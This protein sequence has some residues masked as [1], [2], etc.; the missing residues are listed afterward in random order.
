M[1][2]PILWKSATQIEVPSNDHAA[3]LQLA[4]RLWKQITKKR[5][6]KVNY[7]S[8]GNLSIKTLNV[9]QAGNRVITMKNTPP[10]CMCLN[11][12]T[13]HTHKPQSWMQTHKHMHN[14][15]RA[16]SVGPFYASCVFMRWDC[17]EGKE[18]QYLYTQRPTQQWLSNFECLKIHK[19][20]LISFIWLVLCWRLFKSLAR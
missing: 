13:K 19:E 5:S 14:V 12:Y 18:L 3:E 7:F 10:T 9:W 8:R 4:A 20:H 1:G 17:R 6:V 15:W 16:L 11:M 2:F